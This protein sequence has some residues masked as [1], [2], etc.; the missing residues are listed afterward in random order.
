M[1][2]INLR[3][4]YRNLC[5]ADVCCDVGSDVKDALDTFARQERAA[6]K[7]RQYHGDSFAYIDGVT[8]TQYTP[9]C[10]QVLEKKLMHEALYAALQSLPE[11]QRRRVYARYFLGL[12]LKQIA[13]AE[14]VS[15]VAVSKSIDRAILA[16]R[17]YLQAT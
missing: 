14:S 6:T 8:A 3:A 17:R 4:Y 1:I 2:K 10:E 15:I 16:M 11:K 5:T 12:N 13:D 9:S 7:R